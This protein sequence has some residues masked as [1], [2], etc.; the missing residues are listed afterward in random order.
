MMDEQPQDQAEVS[1]IDAPISEI[2]QSNNASSAENEKV[3]SFPAKEHKKNVSDD[4]RSLWKKN[5]REKF[6]QEVPD[7]KGTLSRGPC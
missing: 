2:D 7:P 4:K 5:Q 1:A 3:V 6:I